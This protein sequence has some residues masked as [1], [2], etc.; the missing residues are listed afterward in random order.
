MIRHVRAITGVLGQKL[1]NRPWY[2]TAYMEHAI[3]GI[4]PWLYLVEA[5]DYGTSAEAMGE[6]ISVCSS[7]VGSAMT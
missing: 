7:P 5:D 3:A 2:M 6:K 1:Y 4:F